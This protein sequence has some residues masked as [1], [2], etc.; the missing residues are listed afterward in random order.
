MPNANLPIDLSLSVNAFKKDQRQG[1]DGI[2]AAPSSFDPNADD[3][4]RKR[5][6]ERDNHGM[7]ILRF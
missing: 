3:D 6:F 1:S 7:P 4:T 2:I 5:I